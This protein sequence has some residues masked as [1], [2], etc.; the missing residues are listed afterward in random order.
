MMM[1]MMV[2]VLVVAVVVVVV[3]EVAVVVMVLVL[4]LVVVVVLVAVVAVMVLLHGTGTASSGACGCGCAGG[5]GGVS[6]SKTI[7]HYVHHL[8][9]CE[10]GIKLNSLKMML[11]NNNVFK[12]C[13][14]GCIFNWQPAVTSVISSMQSA[15]TK[16][17]NMMVMKKTVLQL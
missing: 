3:V 10:L 4:V 12:K 15:T 16:M 8:T 7:H 9:K 1:M 6:I 13:P 2:M 14:P 11:P 5:D 17:I